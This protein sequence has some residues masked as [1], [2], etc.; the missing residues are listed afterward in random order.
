[1]MRIAENLCKA[2]DQRNWGQSLGFI[3]IKPY[4][5]SGYTQ[6]EGGKTYTF[7]KQGGNRLQLYFFDI[8]PQVG[9]PVGRTPDVESPVTFT[10]PDTAR[11]VFWYVAN[12]GSDVLV[13][14]EEGTEATPWIPAEVDLTAE[15][16][17][18]LPPYG[19]YKEIKS[20]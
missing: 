16:I 19:E 18:T 8:E 11:Y 17:A 9:D 20:F 2:A 5:R 13:K 3:D 15:Q 6:I 12:D 1:M 4:W 10:A 7:S 14:I